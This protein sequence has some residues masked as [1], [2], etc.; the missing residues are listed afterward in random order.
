MENISGNEESTIFDRS[1]NT[2]ASEIETCFFKSIK[3]GNYVS[4]LVSV[5]SA[6]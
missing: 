1:F 6:S 5:S 4:G 3:S 2:L